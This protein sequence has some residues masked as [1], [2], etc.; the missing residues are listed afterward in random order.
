MHTQRSY[1]TLSRLSTGPPSA[2]AV[3]SVPVPMDRNRTCGCMYRISNGGEGGGGM[4]Q[5]AARRRQRFLLPQSYPRHP[6]TRPRK[7]PL[8][9]TAGKQARVAWAGQAVSGEGELRKRTKEPTVGAPRLV[10]NAVTVPVSSPTTTLLCNH[11]AIAQQQH[12]GGRG[13]YE[14][15]GGRRREQREACPVR[16][17]GPAAS[18]RT[19]HSCPTR[20]VTCTKQAH[21]VLDYHAKHVLRGG[22]CSVRCL[23]H[24]KPGSVL[25]SNCPPGKTH[26][27]P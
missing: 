10:S 9:G 7:P 27:N 19:T 18:G 26:T 12:E 20:C 2:S 4:G 17:V 13:G 3:T 24:S 25:L 5:P 6:S 11:R 16:P 14:G 8:R 23:S 21:S 15:A 1:G 22:C